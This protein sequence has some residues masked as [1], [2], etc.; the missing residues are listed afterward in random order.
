[1]PAGP[2]D[3]IDRTK[4]RIEEIIA[5][6]EVPEDPL[7]SRNTL[8]WLL[9]IEPEADHALQIA[10]LGH[11]LE[12]AIG[13]SKVS[14]KDYPDYDSFKAAHA[15]NSSDIL[16][17]VMAEYGV[18]E[19]VI[20]EACRLVL[21]HEVGGDPRAQLLQHADSLSFFE[22]NLPLYFKREGEEETRRRALWGYERLSE[23]ERSIVRNV[24]YHNE[25]L[26]CLLR[27]IIQICDNNL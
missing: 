15:R 7:H 20:E 19:D 16:R 8:E 3:S 14:R 27:E 9:K 12:R 5:K 23:K 4:Q 2:M 11:D 10:A 13:D 22:V 1:M 18:Q 21:L 6:S 24:S 26:D 25:R 17:G